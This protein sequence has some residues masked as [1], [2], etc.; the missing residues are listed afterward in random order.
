MR[1]YT[2]VTRQG[3]FEFCVAWRS[4]LPSRDA[5][6]QCV[7]NIACLVF[8]VLTLLPHCARE[9]CERIIA[10]LVF[11][12]RGAHAAINELKS[13]SLLLS[14][15]AR[16]LCAHLPS[17]KTSYNSNNWRRAYHKPSHILSPS[18][19]SIFRLT[20][21]L[22][23]SRSLTHHTHV[24]MVRKKRDRRDTIC[25]D[26]ATSSASFVIGLIWRKRNCSLQQVRVVRLPSQPY[27]ADWL[28]GTSN[29][30]WSLSSQTIPDCS[31]GLWN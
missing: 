4:A 19:K 2:A 15:Y 3:C 22:S 13:S 5:R 28:E 17:Q 9:L 21:I 1:G 14:R 30:M 16:K 27:D 6:E 10:W 25:A 12:S 31:R 11:I 23:P 29:K 24:Y 8:S 7:S 26:G 20:S 18:Q